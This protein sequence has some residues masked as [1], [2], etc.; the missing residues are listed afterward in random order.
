MASVEAPKRQVFS[1]LALVR[2]SRT[3][4]P[5][6]ARRR[7][8]TLATLPA[9]AADARHRHR[10]PT[11]LTAAHARADAAERAYMPATSEQNFHLSDD[12]LDIARN[13][14]RVVAQVLLSLV[15]LA[16]PLHSVWLTLSRAT[17][18]TLALVL[19]LNIV[20]HLLAL[21]QRARREE[22][23]LPVYARHAPRSADARRK[24]AADQHEQRGARRLLQRA[25]KRHVRL[26]GTS[27]RHALRGLQAPPRARRA[28]PA[29][30][31]FCLKQNKDALRGA[32]LLH[33]REAV[34][35]AQ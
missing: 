19:V 28:P 31:A 4:L 35:V 29:A 27:T 2:T 12:M 11:P 16:S 25:R 26:Y 21:H 33:A 13:N 7:P 6:D 1:Q 8:P 23:A 18:N 5:A 30:A 20:V 15:A 24:H 22:A 3:T 14:P 10:R 32:R 17:L 9:D 34:V